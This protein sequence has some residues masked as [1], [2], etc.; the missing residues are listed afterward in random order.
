[1]TSLPRARI[2]C[3][4]A[5]VGVGPR[6]V[7]FEDA[8]D[9]GAGLSIRRDA[10]VAVDRRL[11]GVVRGQHAREIAPVAGEQIREVAHAAHQV[12]LGVPYIS[13]AEARGGRW[14]ELHQPL[15]PLE[16]P[17]AGVIG[18]F[19]GHHLAHELWVER[20]PRGE[21]RDERIV[22]PRELALDAHRALCPCR[23]RGS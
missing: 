5:P 1:M 13:D 15:C 19:R 16:A 23:G 3:Q 7:T 10:A 2:E 20:E 14:H 18:G 8:R 21:A 6:P 11:A 4:L 22:G 9:I 12:V 17:R